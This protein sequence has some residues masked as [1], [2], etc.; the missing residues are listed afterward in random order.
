LWIMLSKWISFVY[1][2]N[3]RTK[4]IYNYKKE[5]NKEKESIITL[6]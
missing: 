2:Y 1:Q 6:N 4:R 3:H 5:K